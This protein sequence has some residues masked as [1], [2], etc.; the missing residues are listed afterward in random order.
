MTVIDVQDALASRSCR[1][2]GCPQDATT[3]ARRGRFA[4][5][6]QRHYDVECQKMRDAQTG[7]PRS[8]R[9]SSAAPLGGYE[10]R[11]KRLVAAGRKLDQAIQRHKES[12][13]GLDAALAEWDEAKRVLSSSVKEAE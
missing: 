13:G 11:A 4:N 12:R 9:P 2:A 8:E 6:C 3:D 1:I 7:V 5:L 10:Q